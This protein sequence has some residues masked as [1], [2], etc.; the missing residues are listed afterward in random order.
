[1]FKR[2]VKKQFN[3]NKYNVLTAKGKVSILLSQRQI[4]PFSINARYNIT[5]CV[6]RIGVMQKSQLAKVPF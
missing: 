6:F 2:D 4:K 1:M 5:A 3:E